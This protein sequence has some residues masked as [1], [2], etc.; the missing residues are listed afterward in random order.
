MVKKKKNLNIPLG[1]IICPGIACT[2]VIK[3]FV[4]FPR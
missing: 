2:W 4:I 3:Y 1:G